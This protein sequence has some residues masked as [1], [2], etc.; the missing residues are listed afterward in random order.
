MPRVPPRCA[1]DVLHKL[2]RR[3]LHRPGFLSHLPS[4]NQKSS[5]REKPQT[6]SRALAADMAH[7]SSRCFLAKLDFNGADRLRNSDDRFAL[8]FGN[9]VFR[10][11][12]GHRE[13]LALPVIASITRLI[14][15]AAVARI[16]PLAPEIHR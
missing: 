15:T 11:L 5:L 8:V 7:S 4:M 9:C 2:F 10:P 3:S 1:P 13:T 12:A 16:M 14:V 6:V